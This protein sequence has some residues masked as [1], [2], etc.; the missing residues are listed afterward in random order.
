MHLVLFVPKIPD[1]DQHHNAHLKGTVSTTTVGPHTATKSH[2]PSN[3]YAQD[4]TSHTPVISPADRDK[5]PGL[6]G[7]SPVK[8]AH[9]SKLLKGCPDADYIVDGFKH[10]FSLEFHGPECTVEARNAQSALENP[11]AVDEKLSYELKLGRIAGP[12]D[13]PPFQNFKCFPLALRE[14]ST[15]GQFRLL[16]NLSY[17]YDDRS[18]NFNISRENSS[19]KYSNINHAIHLIQQHAPRAAM[20]KSDIKEAFRLIPLHPSQ[21]H[22]TGFKWRGKYYYDKCLPMGS[23]SSCKIFET[24]S[25]ALLWILINKYEITSVVKILDDFLFVETSHTL[26]RRNL[27]TFLAMCEYL[28]VPVEHKKTVGPDTIIIFVGIELD[29]VNMLARLPQD[30]L[31]KYRQAVMELRTTNKVTLKTLQS[32]TGKLQ[33]ATAV[34]APGRAFL[35]RMYDHTIGIKKP[36]HFIRITQAIKEDLNTWLQFLE[37]YNGITVIKH[38]PSVSASDLHLY[39]DASKYGYGAT[40][41]TRW[42]QGVWPTSWQG[43][44][45]TVLELYPILM[46]V[47]TFAHKITNSRIIFHCDNQAIVAVINKQS[48]K[49]KKIMQLVRPLVLTL[50]QSNIHFR[51][52]HIPGV[53]NTLCD[54]LSR[55]QATP[56]VLQSFGMQPA[57][58]PVA[59]H[60][61]P[62]NFVLN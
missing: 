23:S 56:E 41:G 6:I 27:F 40:F 9:L 36:W 21:F 61:H 19:V 4:A 39:S 30:K 58:T 26:C 42:F 60:V 18:V 17:P 2:A 29:S 46:L 55:S 45:I 20:A 53:R 22:L 48:S 57:P 8:V 33:F 28:G 12:F 44:D 62:S 43:H 24:F 10:G 31:I 49:C 5:T 52:V 34:V 15:P 1:L 54:L 11:T 50:L 38:S 47:A 14:K 7:A 25:S 51:A 37:H 13:D 59:T 32:T 16:H 35:R 3:T